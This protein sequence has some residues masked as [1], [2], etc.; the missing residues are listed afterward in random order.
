MNLLYLAPI[1]P[2][3]SEVLDELEQALKQTFGW[4]VRRLSAIDMP[5]LARDAV[6]HQFEAVHILREVLPILPVEATRTLAITTEDLFIPM[7][8]F[9][10]GQ[11]QLRGRLALMSLARLRQEFY[12]LP[13]SRLLFLSRAIKEAMHEIGHT[14]GLVHCGEPSCVMSL[15]NSIQH[16]DAKGSELCQGCVILLKD[17]LKKLELNVEKEAQ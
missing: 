15:A 3:E 1:G 5:G 7:L 10:F 2:I 14:F 17:E 4:E 12:G 13:S 6:R 11:A 9:V 8:T 16:V